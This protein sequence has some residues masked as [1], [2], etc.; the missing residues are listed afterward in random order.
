MVAAGKEDIRRWFDRGVDE[1]HKYMLVVFDRMELPDDPDS[2]YYAD[3]VKEVWEKY[4]SI[5]SDV[6]CTVMEVYDLTADREEQMAE[7][8]AWR[9]PE[10]PVKKSRGKRA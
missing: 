7:K 5:G 8:R 9:L 3:S 10:R 4:D 6:F 1:G 2:P